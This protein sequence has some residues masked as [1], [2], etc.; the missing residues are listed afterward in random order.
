MTNSPANR[1]SPVKNRAYASMIKSAD[2]CRGASSE[3]GTMDARAAA[4]APADRVK[5]TAWFRLTVMTSMIAAG[6]AARMS[7]GMS[8]GM[9]AMTSRAFMSTSGTADLSGLFLENELRF[10]PQALETAARRVQVG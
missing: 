7:R 3:A 4:T 6:A 5:V 8:R 10:F 1:M 2:T 9:T